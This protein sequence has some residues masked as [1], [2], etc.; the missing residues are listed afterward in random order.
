MGAACMGGNIP[1]G[2]LIAQMQFRQQYRKELS[3]FNY[4]IAKIAVSSM[5]KQLDSAR[6]EL[7]GLSAWRNGCKCLCVCGSESLRQQVA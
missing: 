3:D 5:R 1:H 6:R 2:S 7:A 4:S